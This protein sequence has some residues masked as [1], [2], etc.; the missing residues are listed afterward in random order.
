MKKIFLHVDLDQTGYIEFSEFIMSS[1]TEKLILT[2]EKLAIAF[3]W[4]DTDGSGTISELEI[5]EA[6]HRIGLHVTL[7]MVKKMMK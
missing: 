1:M 4:F 6:F 3:K 2:H 7:D 5:M